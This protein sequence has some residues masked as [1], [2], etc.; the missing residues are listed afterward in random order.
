MNDRCKVIVQTILISVAAILSSHRCPSTLGQD[1]AQ[2]VSDVT[3]ISAVSPISAVSSNP[4][5]LIPSNA[6][7]DAMWGFATPPVSP[8]TPYQVLARPSHHDL[9]SSTKNKN[10][11]ETRP[12]QPYAYGW[13]GTQPSQHWER[14]FGTR[15]S[16]TQWTL[17]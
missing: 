3:T 10:K 6:G 4:H 11:I 14:S 13:F 12:A 8:P 5:R 2:A 15:N 17:K 9:K 16:Y 7:A 1:T